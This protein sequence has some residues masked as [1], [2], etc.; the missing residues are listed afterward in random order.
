MT[1]VQRLVVAALAVLI[2]TRS[3]LQFYN[4]GKFVN[5]FS[6]YTLEFKLF[7][8]NHQKTV[9]FKLKKMFGKI[10]V[11]INMFCSISNFSQD[12]K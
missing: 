3:H 9:V 11:K 1:T 2:I 10:F 6:S 8:Q 5:L 4:Y 7:E 12:T